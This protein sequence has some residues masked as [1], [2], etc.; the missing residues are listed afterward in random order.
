MP[1]Q[2]VFDENE[3]EERDSFQELITARNGVFNGL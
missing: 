1:L 2:P 3:D